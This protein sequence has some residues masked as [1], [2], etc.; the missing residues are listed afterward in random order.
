MNLLKAILANEVFPAIGCTEPVSCAYAAAVAAE[1][2]GAPV[3]RVDVCVDIGT[4]KNGA[5]VVVPHTGGAKGNRIAVAV[6]AVLARSE[7]RLQ[8]LRD[9]TPEVV[10]KAR[11]LVERGACTCEAAPGQTAFRVEAR[12]AGGGRTAVCI[13]SDGHANIE[14]IE[15]DGR[16]VYERPAGGSDDGLAYRRALGARTVADVLAEVE[17]VDDAD[18]A[19]LLEGVAMNLA[20]AERG[21]GVPGAAA[22]LRRMR[23]VGVLADDLF[24]RVKTHVA[25]AVDARMAGVPEPVMTSGGSGNQGVMATLVPHL[26]GGE[27]GIEP[28]RVVR[29]I[30]VAHAINAYVKVYMGELSAICGCATGAGIAAAVAVVYQH[31]GIDAVRIAHA[32]NNVI[33]DL[34]GQICDGAKAGC[35][36]KTVSGVDA[37]L[38]AAFMAIEGFGLSDDDGV[39]GATAE[40]SIRNLGRVSLEGMLQVDPMVVSILA[41]KAARGGHA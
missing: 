22:Q 25:A 2:L 18:R 1:R 9:V 29:S 28:D 19:F 10:A 17:Q 26:V 20:M 40:E 38:R 13:L 3:E 15:C 12:V 33:G 34:S 14:R 31:A 36:T 6:G 39:L 41:A 24:H 11:A 4:Y 32:V 37:A 23:E 27:R 30:A 16:P 8:L 5:A 7:G 21:R 35:A